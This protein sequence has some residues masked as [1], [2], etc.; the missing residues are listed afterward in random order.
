[1]GGTCRPR[2]RSDTYERR[3]KMKR[4][5]VEVFSDYSAVLRQGGQE[6]QKVLN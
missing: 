2:Q 3:E 5:W 4:D 6:E 1:M